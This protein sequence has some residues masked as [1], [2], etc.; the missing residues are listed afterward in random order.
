MFLLLWCVSRRNQQA[1]LFEGNLPM[2]EMAVSGKPG[3]PG[4]FSNKL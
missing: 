1:K 3:R 2:L 4:N